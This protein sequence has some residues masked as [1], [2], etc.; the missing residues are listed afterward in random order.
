MPNSTEFR[1]RRRDSGQFAHP[2]LA[3]ARGRGTE[4]LVRGTGVG[5]QQ[6]ADLH[7]ES[8]DRPLPGRLCTADRLAE[9]VRATIG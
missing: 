2:T 3:N 5:Y 6:R 4:P 1:L 7:R 8:L 9:A